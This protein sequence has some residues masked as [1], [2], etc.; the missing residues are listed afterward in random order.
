MISDVDEIPRPESVI[1]AAERGGITIFRQLMFS[2]FL[3]C[4]HLA[5][6]GSPQPIWHGTVAY[7]HDSKAETPQRYSDL[8][9]MRGGRGDR[10]QNRLRG[11]AR[12]ARRLGAIEGRARFAEKAGWHFSYQGGVNAIIAKRGLLARRVQ[13]R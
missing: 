7:R 6:D 9:Y 2:Y 1:A 8:R 12:R 3:N 11:A 10:L 4:L 13:H 5:D